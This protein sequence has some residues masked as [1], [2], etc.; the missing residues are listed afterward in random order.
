MRKCDLRGGSRLVVVRKDTSFS[1]IGWN[2]RL[3]FGRTVRWPPAGLFP[4]RWVLAISRVGA[5][6]RGARK[7]FCRIEMLPRIIARHC[8]QT[9]WPEIMSWNGSSWIII[10]TSS[11]ICPTRVEASCVILYREFPSPKLRLRC[12]CEL[13]CSMHYIGIVALRL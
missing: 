5:Y 4:R 8:L 7:I 10:S 12:D 9:P 6:V 11:T 3:P 13:N 2:C 1:S